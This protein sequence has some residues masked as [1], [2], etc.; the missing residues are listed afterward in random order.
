MIP[1]EGWLERGGTRLH[2]LDWP[3][4][5]GRAVF[6]L[7]GLSSNAR[8]WSRVAQQLEGRRFVALDQRSHGRSDRSTEADTIDTFVGDA[9]G[10]IGALALDRPVLAGHSWGATVALE[11]AA[12]HPDAI[13]ALA[14]IDGPAWPLADTV[15]WETFATRSQPPLPRYAD[16]D[17]AVAAARAW[18]GEAWDDDLLEFVRAGHLDEEGGLVL[19]LT[20]DARARI[21]RDLYALRQDRAWATLAVPAFAAFAERKSETMLAATRRAAE[22]V[23]AVAPKVLVRWYDS[24]HDI[25]LVRPEA[26]ARDIAML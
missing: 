3:G 24:P 19:P 15:V 22:R 10:A 17:A 6:A 11:V 25:P 7:H 14:F 1:R 8:F 20:H 21:L 18:H 5:S 16:L 26:I 9:I 4:E 12:R 13:S 23:A 2:Y